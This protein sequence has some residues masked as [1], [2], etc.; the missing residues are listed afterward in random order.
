MRNLHNLYDTHGAEGGPQPD[1][2][3]AKYRWILC[4][5]ESG[6]VIA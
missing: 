5:A 1:L 4:E 3:I 2:R 6:A